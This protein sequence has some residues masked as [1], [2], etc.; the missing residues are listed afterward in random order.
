MI[1][2]AVGDILVSGVHANVNMV[3]RRFLW[4][5]MQMISDL[6]KPWLVIGDFN[7]IL[8][9][10]D[11]VGG[12]SPSR[13][14]MLE[15]GEY[16]NT[17]D[18][19]QAPKVGLDF[20]WSNCQHGSK[21]I[22][23][24]LYRTVFNM[25]WLR[26]YSDWGYKVDA[27]VVSDHSPLMGEGV[28]IPRPTNVPLRFQKMW[29]EHPGFMKVVE[30]SWAEPVNG[31]PAFT[32]IYKLKRLKIILKEWNLK[33]FGN[34]QVEIKE[35]EK[36][37]QEKMIISYSNP[38]D[39]QALADLV[40]AQN[41]LNSKEVPHCI[42][43]KQKSR[44]KWATKGSSNT[45]FFHTNVKIRQTRNM[46]CELEDEKGNIV[47]DQ[48]KITDVLVKFFHH[49]FQYKEVTIDDSL[50][51]IIPNLISD[52]DQVMIEVVP[53]LEEIKNAVFSMNADGAPGPDSF[54]GNSILLE[55]KI[56]PKGREFQ[57][58]VLLPE[59]HGAKK[60][61]QFRPIGLSNFNFKIF[62][63]ILA[64]R[65]NDLMSKLVSKQQAAYIKG[66]SIHE[67]VMLASELVNEMKHTIRGGNVGLKLDISQ[68]Y[69][70]VSWDFLFKVLRKYGFPAACCEWLK[71]LFASSK[72]YIMINGGP[73]GFFSMERGL[74]QR[75]PLSPILFVLMEELL[76]RN[77][78]KLVKLKKLRPM[79]I[80]KG[81]YPTHL[82]FADDVFIFSNGSTKKFRSSRHSAQ[83]L[84]GQ[85]WSDNQQTEK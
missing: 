33:I 42:M 13:R 20:T 58:L 56:Y 65:M 25:E 47:A 45:N 62:T 79:V 35:E 78:T 3:Q 70:S 24:T 74:K 53:E 11:K 44:I 28:N 23:C 52:Q 72:I 68:A 30:D 27:R 77:L 61:N 60:P 10:E 14:S 84:S 76:S 63:Q 59:V 81:V 80:M 16:L 49:K 31:D 38:H 34:V 83:E 64:T 19:I 5:E 18:L 39:E 40:M 17:C 8:S 50:L 75:D 26:L 48:D 69:D 1:I 54:S 66:R 6:K 82:F 41:D 36:L 15:V 29:L 12:K 22:L 55:E 71:T 2:V 37:V 32:L 67:Q 4:Y 73:Q 46:I 43:M 9:I 7:L 57:F 85:F 51:D 21:R